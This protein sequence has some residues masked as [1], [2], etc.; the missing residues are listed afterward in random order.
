MKN[1]LMYVNPKRC[2][3]EEAEKLIKIQIDNSLDL[4][5]ARKDIWLATNFWFEYNGIVSLVVEDD[6][7]CSYS[8]ISTKIPVVLK[9]FDYGMIDEDELYWMHDLDAFQLDR[10][11]C[12]EVELN[13]EDMA[14]CDYGRMPKW[15]GGSVFFKKSAH[16]LFK[17][18]YEVMEERQCVDENAITYLTTTHGNI[19]FRIRKQNI[20]YNFLPYNIRSCYAMAIKPIRVAHFHP[21]RPQRQTGILK[22][23]D[24]YKG[25]N[26]I[27]TQILP[28]RIIK[29]FD[30]HGVK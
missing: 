19:S 4:G 25:D 3:D 10:F 11:P 28:D 12:H 2:F 18:I 5:W 8:P 16:D 14:L 9:L 21:L 17:R 29:I 20:S 15:A 24:F 13:T 30:E 6:L 23:L 1:I 27:S 22:P 7:Y 26:K